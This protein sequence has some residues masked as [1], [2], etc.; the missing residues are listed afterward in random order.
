MPDRIVVYR[1]AF[2]RVQI[3]RARHARQRHQG[4]DWVTAVVPKQQ[5]C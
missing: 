2:E 4:G 5:V 3:L 1:V